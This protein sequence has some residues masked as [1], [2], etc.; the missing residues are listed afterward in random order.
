MC[1]IILYKISYK[2]K[3][4][5]HILPTKPHTTYLCPTGNNNKQTKKK[6][7]RN[8]KTYGRIKIP[9][10]FHMFYVFYVKVGFIYKNKILGN[11][12]HKELLIGALWAFEYRYVMNRITQLSLV[13][14]RMVQQKII[15]RIII[16]CNFVSKQMYYY[17]IY[18]LK[19]IME[20]G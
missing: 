3:F 12:F 1:V 10:S 8:S 6:K 11:L 18:M 20:L 14:Y 16:L 15:L 2:R 9:I 17:I 5:K 7:K 4:L 19:Y 13:S